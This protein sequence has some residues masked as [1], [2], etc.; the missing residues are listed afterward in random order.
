MGI[1]LGS[2]IVG[3]VGY[4][5]RID[6]TAI[7]SV[8]NLASRLCGLADDTQILVDPVVA[9]GVKDSIALE[10]LGVRSIKGY[11]H[12]LQIFVVARTDY[13]NRILKGEQP[14]NL[15]AAA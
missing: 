8:V 11:D 15:A 1:A 5:G 7:G 12:P 13:A 3:T 6:Y 9:E 14:A 10:S 2:A 4:E